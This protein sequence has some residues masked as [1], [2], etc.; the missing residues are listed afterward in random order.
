MTST[1]RALRL[2][3]RQELV[4]AIRSRFL[5]IFAIVFATL[6]LLVASSGYILTGGSGMQDFSRTAAS[7][8]ELVLLVVP[9][10]AL[11]IGVTAL[12]PEIGSA[13]LLYSQPVARR[14]ILVG[15]LLGLVLALVAAEAIGFG[16]S[17]L[18]LFARTGAGGLGAFAGVAGASVL[19]TVL[20]LSL[21]AAITG[22]GASRSRARNLAVALVV[23]LAGVALFD[24]AALGVASL[25]PSG[26]ASRVLMISA[27]ANP[28]DAVRTG[29]LMAMQGTTAFGAAS[30][31]F[32][33]FTHGSAAAA[34]WL[35]LSAAFWIVVPLLVG[36]RRLD[37]ADI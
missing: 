14:T 33:R 22:G 8:V 6:A 17:G 34:G 9:L 35:A 7:L 28:V 5:V 1:S 25:L 3:A 21:A 24:V 30:L 16:A 31:A 32:L 26:A 10:A 19:L 13:E 2:C 20:F 15:K 29:T 36:A 4:L 37:R 12:T 27:I 11:V 18:V 23:W